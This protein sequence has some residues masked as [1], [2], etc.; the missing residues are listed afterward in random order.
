MWVRVPLQSLQFLILHLFRARRSLTFGQLQKVNSLQTHIWP[1]KNTQSSLTFLESNSGD[2]LACSWDI[3]ELKIT[4]SDWPR[5]FLKKPYYKPTFTSL[6]FLFACQKS[7]W[8]INAYLK[9]SWL[10]NSEIW[11][12]EA[13]FHPTQQ[14]C[15]K[16]PFIFLKSILAGKK[17]ADWP[18]Y[19]WDYLI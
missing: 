5:A 16:S 10:K 9:H 13:I 3:A 12:P 17:Y 14:K 15:F 19:S 11:L 8:F 4:K 6:K 2:W 18:N 7:S 1:N